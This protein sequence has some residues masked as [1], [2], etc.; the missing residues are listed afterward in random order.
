MIRVFIS[1]IITALRY[2]GNVISR[3]ELFKKLFSLSLLRKSEKSRDK[4]V[5]TTILGNKFY[6]F[7]YHTLNYLI[8][9]IIVNDEYAFYS[10]NAYPVI[11]DCGANIGMSVLYF[12]RCYPQ[13]TIIAFEP[14]PTTYS[15]LDKNIS[16]FKLTNVTLHNLALANSVGKIPFH[17]NDDKGTLTGSIQS[18]RGGSRVVEV[19]CEKLS[20]FI[21]EYSQIDLIKMDVEGAELKIVEDLMQSGAISKVKELIV[22]YHH[23]IPGENNSLSHFL[24]MFEQAGFDYSIRTGFSSLGVMQD[25]L[26][27]FYRKS[28]DI[29]F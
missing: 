3:M 23:N 20:S 21:N 15:L 5:S 6:A 24:K 14:N 8:R 26:L 2:K 10:S 7:S 22:E 19:S 13:S 27:H 18:N 25:V 28:P 12:K 17:F 29:V 4:E 1:S 11:I 9:E 16:S